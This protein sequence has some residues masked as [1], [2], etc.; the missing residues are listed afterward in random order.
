MSQEGRLCLVEDV[1]SSVT[2]LL[3]LVQTVDNSS[4]VSPVT[5]A[6]SEVVVESDTSEESSGH[7][8]AD[9][10]TCDVRSQ[11]EVRVSDKVNTQ[12]ASELGV[13][14]SPGEL[15]ITSTVVAGVPVSF[16]GLVARLTWSTSVFLDRSD[17][18]LTDGSREDVSKFSLISGIGD[19]SL[20]N[21]SG[22]VDLLL[23][24]RAALAKFPQ[25]S[26]GSWML[27]SKT[28]DSQ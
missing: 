11:S 15:D 13:V 26:G 12:K 18:R 16:L 19:A 9:D 7:T 1:E 6:S 3:S 10:F 17:A 8:E 27:C 28:T 5:A 14:V 25:H 24:E 22:I 21:I 20:E 23:V 2:E 4:G